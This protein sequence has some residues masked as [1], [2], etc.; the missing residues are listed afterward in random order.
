MRNLNAFIEET[1]AESI[2][3]ERRHKSALRGKLPGHEARKNLLKYRREQRKTPCSRVW[4]E[5]NISGASIQHACR[6]SRETQAGYSGQL[7]RM[8]RRKERNLDVYLCVKE[9]R[10]RVCVFIVETMKL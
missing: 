2:I 8:V 3:R 9:Q 1:Y 4:S 6:R 7:K 10:S 5:P